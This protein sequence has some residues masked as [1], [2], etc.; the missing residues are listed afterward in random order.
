S[1]PLTRAGVQA[2]PLTREDPTDGRPRPPRPHRRRRRRH[3]QPPR[4]LQAAR[5][6]ARPP[7]GVARPPGSLA[8]PPAA[9]AAPGR[10]PR[11][12]LDDELRPARPCSALEALD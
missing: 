6:P 1:R 5:A 2:G 3:G 10:A 7:A 9:P 4:R 8:R 12:A 11:L